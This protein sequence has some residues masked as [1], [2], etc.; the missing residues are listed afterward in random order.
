MIAD[1]ADFVT[2]VY[3]I[4]D[5]LWKPISH[6][7]ARPGPQPSTCSDSELMTMAIVSE[8]RGRDRETHAHAEWA[9]YRDLFPHQPTRT[10]LNRRRHN[11]MGAIN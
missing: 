7:Y 9:Q 1:F 11:L 2:W 8:C 4:V 3:V 5:D 6:L 10:R